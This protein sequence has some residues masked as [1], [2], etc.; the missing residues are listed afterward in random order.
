MALQFRIRRHLGHEHEGLHLFVQH[1][2]LW[3]VVLT[4][5]A[6]GRGVCAYAA[7]NTP[8]QSHNT[9]KSTHQS[10]IRN[11]TFVWANEAACSGMYQQ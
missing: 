10:E 7:C 1:R 2:N 11:P 6:P 9:I 5:C 4:K 3:R 8:A